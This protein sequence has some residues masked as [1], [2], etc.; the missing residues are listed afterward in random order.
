MDPDADKPAPFAIVAI[1]DA[2]AAGPKIFQFNP[3]PGP[4]SMEDCFF[5]YPTADITLG[6]FWA[7][8]AYSTHFGLLMIVRDCPD[9]GISSSLPYSHRLSFL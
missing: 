9:C 4:P 1:A 5:F 3:I 2:P 8:L 6:N 7:F